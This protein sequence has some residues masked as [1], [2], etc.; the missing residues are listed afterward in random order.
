MPSVDLDVRKLQ[1]FSAAK[2]SRKRQGCSML[3]AR[4]FHSRVDVHVLLQ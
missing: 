3:F 2:D 1:H 4:F